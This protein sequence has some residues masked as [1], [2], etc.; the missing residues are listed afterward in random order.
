MDREPDEDRRGLRGRFD[1]G[2]RRSSD[3]WAA[4]RRGRP[5]ED[6]APHDVIATVRDMS[7]ARDAVQALQMAGVDAA[8]ISLYGPSADEAAADLDVRQADAGF[9]AVMWRRTW[10][11]GL[12]GLLIGAALGAVGAAFV[13]RGLWPEAL[14]VFWA[15]VVGT[16]VLGL[17]TGAA[18]GATSAAQMS[19]AWELTFH[20]VGPGEVG[21]AVHSDRAEEARRAER[22]LERFEP[23]QLERFDLPRGPSAQ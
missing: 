14:G 11:G 18:T 9:S 3:P 15:A 20:D 4:R 10:I 21:V 7:R 2:R 16:A 8:Q 5:S 12:S 19:R 17:G 13:L 22:V 23:S 6:F 1:P